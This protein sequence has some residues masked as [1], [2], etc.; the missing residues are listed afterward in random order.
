VLVMMGENDPIVPLANG[1]LLAGAIPDA[2][3]EVFDGAGH[4]FLMT[5]PDKAIALLREFLDAPGPA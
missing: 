5:H 1:Q 3:L 2:R 4:L